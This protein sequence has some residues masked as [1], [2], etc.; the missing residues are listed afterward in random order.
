MMMKVNCSCLSLVSIVKE[1]GGVADSLILAISAKLHA[2][3]SALS[4]VFSFNLL[5]SQ[6]KIFLVEAR[7]KVVGVRENIGGFLRESFACGE[8]RPQVENVA[9]DHG[10]NPM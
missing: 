5:R 1:Q 10:A 2:I 4:L 6:N 7:G 8:K 3:K 9:A